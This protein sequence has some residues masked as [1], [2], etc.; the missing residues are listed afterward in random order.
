MTLPELN[1]ILSEKLTNRLTIQEQLNKI[2]K[3]IDE[4]NK[5]IQ[6]KK[7][8]YLFDYLK[9]GYSHEI[10]S[11]LSIRMTPQKDAHNVSLKVGDKFELV[12]RNKKSFVIKVVQYKKI[13]HNFQTKTTSEEII[14]P[15]WQYRVPIEDLYYNLLKD[16]EFSKNFNTWISRQEI[17]NSLID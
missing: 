5:Q 17:L 12:K 2:H 11:Y 1:K 14:Y 8:D 7:L 16:A 3:E 15:N 10:K 9:I 13:K 4:I 6:L